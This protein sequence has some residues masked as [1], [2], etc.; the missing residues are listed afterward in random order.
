M[1]AVKQFLLQNFPVVEIS[2]SDK[3]SIRK[4]FG[5]ISYS[6]K[7]PDFSEIHFHR[8]FFQN[9]IFCSFFLLNH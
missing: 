8:K 2:K 7:F 1:R 5:M 9:Q 6:E 3:V 4:N